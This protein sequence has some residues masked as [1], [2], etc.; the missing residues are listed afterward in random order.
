M[1]DFAALRAHNDPV[2]LGIYKHYKHTEMDPRYYLVQMVARHTETEE[3]LVIYVPLYVAGGL[4]A[5]ARPLKI[6]T[7][8]VTYQGRRMP[9]FEYVG[10]EIPEYSV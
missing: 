6:F 8:T 7:G 9:R 5:A 3:A 10:M 1:A 2:R 4:R